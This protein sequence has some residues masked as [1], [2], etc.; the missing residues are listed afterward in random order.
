[1]VD[2]LET[3]DVGCEV[4]DALVQKWA[5][6]EFVHTGVLRRCLSRRQAGQ[7]NK[8]SDSVGLKMSQELREHFDISIQLNAICSKGPSYSHL[9]GR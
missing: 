9:V 3:G 7:R 6:K 4:S 1:M 8:T 5:R 2:A